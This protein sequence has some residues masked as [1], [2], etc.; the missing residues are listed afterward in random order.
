[1]SLELKSDKQEKLLAQEIDKSTLKDMFENGN[2]S[3]GKSNQILKSLGYYQG[4]AE[5]FRTNIRHGIDSKNSEDIKWRTTYGT[6]EPTPYEAKGILYFIVDSLRDKM[7]QILL[8]ASVISLIIGILQ[9]GI[10]KGWIEG[11]AIFLA[12]F[13]VVSISSFNNWSKEQQFQKLY[14]ERRNR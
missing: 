6:N 8:A 10:Q 11:F 4:L 14:M 3:S 1:M 7:L 5:M 9:E 13:I 2:I 12:V